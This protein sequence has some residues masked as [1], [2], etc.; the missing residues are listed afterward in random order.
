MVTNAPRIKQ[1]Q[2]DFVRQLS[3]KINLPMTQIL[4]QALN[5]YLAKFGFQP[6]R[7]ADARLSSEKPA[8]GQAGRKDTRSK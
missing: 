4:K 2:M 5:E 8:K 1:N 6:E 3:R 7:G